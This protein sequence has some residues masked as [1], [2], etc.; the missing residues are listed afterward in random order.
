MAK[1]SVDMPKHVTL[2]G[3]YYE[4]GVRLIDEDEAKKLESAGKAKIL[5]PDAKAENKA[6]AHVVETKAADTKAEGESAEAK[7][8][9]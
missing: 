3:K 1:V 5:K 8:K 2:D 9:K 4:G 7:P 6:A